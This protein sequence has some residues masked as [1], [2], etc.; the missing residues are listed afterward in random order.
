MDIKIR[1]IEKKDHA[2][3][4]ELLNDTI[5]SFI[6][7]LDEY[8]TIWE[9]FT[10]QNNVYSLVACIDDPLLYEDTVV[11]YYSMTVETKIRG[12]KMAHLEEMAILPEFQRRGIGTKM[13]NAMMDLATQLKCYRIGFHGR[14]HNVEFYTAIGFRQAETYFYKSLD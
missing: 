3:V 7:P 2:Q 8:E 11:G 9:N 10:S 13:H 5:S 12:G 4:I 14:L 6:P 1:K